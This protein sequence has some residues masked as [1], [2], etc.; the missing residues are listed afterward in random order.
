MRMQCTVQI[1]FRAFAGLLVVFAILSHNPR[2]AQAG[3][4]H[5]AAQA[6]LT[7]GDPAAT[8]FLPIGTV[9]TVSVDF[10]MAPGPTY[11]YPNISST[12]G[13]FSWNDGTSRVFDVND[14]RIN[15]SN[16]DGLVGIVF[17]GVAP[18]IPGVAALEFNIFYD[19]GEAVYTPG[20]L[21]THLLSSTIDSIWVRVSHAPGVGSGLGFLRGDISGSVTSAVPE[22]SSFLIASTLLGGFALVLTIRRGQ[23]RAVRLAALDQRH[24]SSHR[25]TC[26]SAGC[27]SL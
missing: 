11:K 7:D 16:S 5:T 2:A 12:V 21:S 26:V 27:P 8:D 13:T 1:F 14:A 4:L 15:Y 6:T 18:S 24:L 22:P 23:S 10:E 9:F 19:V 17:Q 25:R 3:L 20:D